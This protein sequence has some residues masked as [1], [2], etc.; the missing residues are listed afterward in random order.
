MPPGLSGSG[1][2][3]PDRRTSARPAR[4]GY[5]EYALALPDYHHVQALVDGSYNS[6][7]DAGLYVTFNS[8]WPATGEH[9]AAE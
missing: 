5:G 2:T 1:R 7:L 9:G 4:R 8:F 6:L 3:G